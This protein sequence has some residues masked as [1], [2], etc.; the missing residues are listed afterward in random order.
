MW[1]DVPPALRDLIDIAAYVYAADSAITRGS[2]TD[3]DLGTA[4]RRC[5]FF[6]IPV[7]RP[8]LWRD[9]GVLG[10]LA[11]TLSFLAEDEYHFQFEPLR[12][13][14]PFQGYFEFRDDDEGGEVQEVVLFSGGL[15]SLAGAVQEAVVG[16][17]RILLVHHRS[18]SKRVPRHEQLL[19]RLREHAPAAPPLHIPVRID[20]AKRFDREFTQRSR[21]FL[22]A[23]LGAALAV[24]VR[25]ARVCFFENGIV[26]INLPP[27]AQVVGARATRTTHPQFLGDLTRLLTQL[28]GSPLEVVNPFRWNTKTEVVRFIA[29]AGCADLISLA[30]SCTHVWEMTREHTHCGTCS[31]CIDRRFAALAAG[32]EAADPGN[33]YAVDLLTGPRDKGHPRT[34]LAVFLETANQLARLGV[35]TFFARYGEATRA[36][37]HTGESAE[38]TALKIFELY[39]KHARDVNGVVDRAIATYAAALRRRELPPSCLIGL[40]L[41]MGTSADTEDRT[42][43]GAGTGSPLADNVFRKDGKV[44][45]VRFAG[46]RPFVL[47]PSRG[48]SYLHVLLSSRGRALA[49]VDLVYRVTRNPQLYA[50]GNAGEKLDRAGLAALWARLGELD[51]EIAE[52]QADNDYGAL[53]DLQR[54]REEILQ[55]VRQSVGLRGRIRIESDDRERVRVAVRGAIRRVVQDIRQEDARLAEHLSPPNLQCGWNPCYAPDP[56]VHWE[57]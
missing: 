21:S 26:S 45:R 43:A 37:L 36:L 44:W 25:Q 50:A 24:M 6:R 3:Q 22:F 57:T 17:R 9:S 4:W 53:A 31:Q 49:V 33:A 1:G 34:M 16:G 32:L 23:A 28:H 15:D 55:Q 29:E 40:V 2:G 8:D 7:R 39:Q 11:R 56:D 30:T 42:Q 19:R 12:D 20:K 38:S 14:P 46:G 54:E 52:A 48:A 51:E 13:E 10:Q 41:D 18:A 47:L 27:S 5:L 35:G